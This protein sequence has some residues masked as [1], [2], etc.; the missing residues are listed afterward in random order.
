MPRPNK[1]FGNLP[2][3]AFTE[4]TDRTLGRVDLFHDPTFPAGSSNRGKGDT[5]DYKRV[6]NLSFRSATIN[7]F[8]S[9]QHLPV[10][11]KS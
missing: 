4:R 2:S 5:D 6:V 8:F 1:Y 7:I 9:Q 3:L 11:K 10:R